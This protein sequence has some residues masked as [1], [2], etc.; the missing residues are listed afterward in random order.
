MNLLLL[1]SLTV[2]AVMADE[3]PNAVFQ[4]SLRSFSSK[5]YKELADSSPGNF[6]ACPLSSELVLAMVLNGARDQTAQQLAHAISVPNDL[7]TTNKIVN[8]AISSIKTGSTYTLKTVNKIFVSNDTTIKSGFA[9]TAAEIFKSSVGTVDFK[10]KQASVDHVNAWAADNTENRITNLLTTQDIKDDTRAILLNAIYFQ[11]TWAKR[12]HEE[13]TIEKPFYTSPTKTSPVKM[14]EQTSTFEY[15]DQPNAQFLKMSYLG[16]DAVMV[17]VLPKEKDGL[18]KLEDQI[19]NVLSAKNFEHKKV[20]V[21]FPKFTMDTKIKMKP[22]LERLGVIDLFKPT[23]D[24]T[25]LSDNRLYISEVVQKNYI[26]VNEKG[27]IAASATAA[28]AG[29]GAGYNPEEPIEFAVDHPFIYYIWSPT[30]IMFVGRLY[31]P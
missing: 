27:T 4:E 6:L 30:G 17:V 29:V 23:A 15:L 19:D 28:I 21:L 10:N 20:H 22:L 1:A 8:S 31:E 9:K 11:A 16:T 7:A 18:S 14:M 26:E 5:I 3:D 2:I 24:L 25:D 13:N 12:F